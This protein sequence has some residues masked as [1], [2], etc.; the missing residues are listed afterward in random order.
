M[1][2][3]ILGYGT[4]G[5]GV[6]D[7]IQ[8]AKTEEIQGLSVKAILIR[9]NKER[10]LPIMTYHFND[11]LNDE[12]I[13]CVIEVLGGRHPAKEY[14]KEA[15]S[16]GKHVVTANKDVVAKYYTEF[17]SLALE[18]GVQFRFEASVGGGMPWIKALLEAKQ[19]DDIQLMY[20]ILNGTTNF[21]LDRMNRF[22][23]SFQMALA[24]ASEL[25][26][27]E[28]NPSNDIDGIDL[29]NKLVI[30]MIVAYGGTINPQEIPVHGIRDVSAETISFYRKLQYVVKLVCF[31][32][33]TNSGYDVAVEPMLFDQH[34][35]A[36]S[37]LENFNMGV[38]RGDTIGE[39]TYIGQGAGKYPTANAV[40]CD[41]L[42][43]AKHKTQSNV[44]IV[45]HSLPQSQKAKAQFWL[46]IPNRIAAQKMVELLCEDVIEE[47]GFEAGK[48]YFKTKLMLT[49]RF[50]HIVSLMKNQGVEVIYARIFDSMVKETENVME[51]EIVRKVTKEQVEAKAKA[52]TKIKTKE[53]AEEEKEKN[54]KN[55][56]IK[57]QE[58]AG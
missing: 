46:S 28:Q 38:I 53:K 22:G 26:Y 42:E 10:L 4:V 45:L 7:I 48:L 34:T 57:K 9:K 54:E 11:I 6:Y 37:I 49:S 20:G 15:L 35:V 18:H 1:K 55:E 16:R 25:G 24:Q 43:I 51:N 36:A 5:Q 27:A 40:L 13:S 17:Q 3:A 12:E 32:R 30:S 47:D 52:N 19:I 14:I 8:Q 23:E 44:P 50:Y 29:R 31:A 2:I 56:K 39:L 33:L 41:I 21:V 58:V